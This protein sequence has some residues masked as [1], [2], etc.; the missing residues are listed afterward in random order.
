MIGLG[1]LFM[2]DLTIWAQ[3]VTAV[4]GSGGV[5]FG[6]VKWFANHVSKIQANN[7]K[8]TATVL[9]QIDTNTER[10][11]KSLKDEKEACEKD[12]EASRLELRHTVEA[13]ERSLL[14]MQDERQ[15]DR[16]LIRELIGKPD[17]K[18]LPKVE[19]PPKVTKQGD[20]T[21]AD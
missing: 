1:D 3:V 20:I 17:F 11:I 16:K 6:G 5:V 8:I 4:I 7:D 19:E 21:S 14:A 18:V 13:F 10:F 2:A 12:R 15:E 9:Q